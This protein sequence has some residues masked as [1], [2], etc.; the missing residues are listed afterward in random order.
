[1]PDCGLVRCLHIRGGA[2]DSK[3]RHESSVRTL[4]CSVVDGCLITL[5]SNCHPPRLSQFQ[6][7]DNERA[8]SH[9]ACL[10]ARATAADAGAAPAEAADTP[11]PMA[12]NLGLHLEGPF[13]NPAKK[14]A[15]AAAHI[16]A[17]GAALAADGA[18]A[19]SPE[20][21]APGK[22]KPSAESDHAASIAALAAFEKIY[23]FPAEKPAAAYASVA[24][25][26]RGP[27]SHA[28]AG[29]HQ[30]LQQHPPPLPHLHPHPHGFV[31]I[32]TL[33]PELQRGLAL[34]SALS[35]AGV[36]V[37]IG[38]SDAHILEADAA[39]RAG[40]VLITH[41]FNAMSA[42]NH[43]DPG[44]PGL[45]GRRFGGVG[46]ARA[47][48]TRARAGL[49][50]AQ[51]YGAL[52]SA[53]HGDDDD[54]EHAG[55]ARGGAG[56]RVGAQ[57]RRAETT[58][59]KA[60]STIAGARLALEAVASPAA[61]R[62][63]GSSQ[64]QPLPVPV[65]ILRQAS[66]SRAALRGE[67]HIHN[68]SHD[69]PRAVTAA[70]FDAR[71]VDATSSSP[72]P[73]VLAAA[74]TPVL[75]S[76]APAAMGLD[77]GS[78]VGTGSLHGAQRSATFSLASHPFGP[79]LGIADAARA[80]RAS[81][82]RGGSDHDAAGGGMADADA[83]AGGRA[84]A[85]G[86]P[87]S[88]AVAGANFLDGEASAPA[89][90]AA[91]AAD[92]EAGVE[93]AA[94]V[95]GTRICGDVSQV[96]RMPTVTEEGSED[97]LKDGTGSGAAT[98][99]AAAAAA[100]TAASAVVATV[101]AA[102]TSPL[103]GL[104]ERD[105]VAAGVMA[106]A[107]RDG[108]APSSGCSGSSDL[109][110]SPVRH[111]ATAFSLLSAGLPPKARASTAG[112]SITS[113]VAAAPPF[114]FEASSGGTAAPFKTP[115]ASSASVFPIAASTGPSIPPSMTA[116]AAG[117]PHLAPIHAPASGVAGGSGL[118][119]H[120]TSGSHSSSSSVGSG[121][122]GRTGG[123]VFSISSIGGGR[124][125]FSVAAPRLP[126]PAAPQQAQH[127]LSMPPAP[128]GASTTAVLGTPGDPHAAGAAAGSSGAVAGIP[129][130]G[131]TPLPFATMGGHT[132]GVSF[133]GAL[134]AAGDVGVQAAS[135]AASLLPRGSPP[136]DFTP[137]PAVDALSASAAAEAAP[138][139][140]DASE[141]AA[142]SALPSKVLPVSDEGRG[143][144]GPDDAG[145]A[146]TPF[147]PLP[148]R[149][150]LEAAAAAAAPRSAAGAPL[151]TDGA[152]A[153][154]DAAALAGAGIGGTAAA[155]AALKDT[156]Q[157]LVRSRLDGQPF[158]S[159]IA[160][161]VHVHPYAVTM[162]AS[163]HPDGLILVT[164]AMQAMGLPPGRHSLAGLQV[165]IF[166]GEDDGHY[167][168]PHAVLAG[169]TTL[170]GAVVPLDECLRNLVAF[171]RCPVP[172]ALAAVTTHPAALL[173]LSNELGS[174]RTGAWADLVILDHGLNVQHTLLAGQL[175]W[176]RN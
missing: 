66:A 100:A 78:D 67:E 77:V 20:N 83:G 48:V 111:P 32:V 34:T 143:T 159:L 132:P 124:L 158:Y 95:Q 38:H 155:L 7:F 131:D 82:E 94:L 15:H 26:H 65:R 17:A 161:G 96:A 62:D 115:A 152:A 145:A 129:S 41:L 122:P 151:P 60:A 68:H 149:F 21:G 51:W 70:A 114:V 103:R 25:G 102:P 85:F 72:A 123:S 157:R 99:A 160:D 91:E 166:H 165:D 56:A 150:P 117:S 141:T 14:G 54:T 98:P 75:P 30:Q 89:R 13:I 148:F 4:F 173:G 58:D 174:L 125:R 153:D 162:A 156:P 90:S 57:A 55:S 147:S 3:S 69:V 50:V 146:I 105:R 110:G 9:K 73:V 118:R 33:A 18:E 23:G 16:R 40:A 24:L 134:G 19:A 116:S 108:G 6:D 5:P 47:A 128:V 71:P 44:I 64:S 168:G 172:A 107:S 137:T 92:G 2:A 61:A 139:A 121:A 144:H 80:P 104:Q 43:R 27:T 59:A 176:S 130:A 101:K 171:T 39:V 120:T 109:G 1:M 37:A 81:S 31:R 46:A 8:A 79:G 88:D 36:V 138:V 135:A 63:A 167:G 163:T 154:D 87:G 127:Q 12:R 97:N 11:F 113:H 126:L 76:A 53:P 74:S 175:A 140:A 93:D 84:G 170:A 28:A 22:S 52:G 119:S 42:F 29:A 35:R 45:L 169:T 164:D 86:E 142:T 133:G 49:P 10:A 136:A 112:S 106:S